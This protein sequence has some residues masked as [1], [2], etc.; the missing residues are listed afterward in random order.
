MFNNPNEDPDAAYDEKRQEAVDKGFNNII[1]MLNFEDPPAEES[2]FDQA[3][4][5]TG[6]TDKPTQE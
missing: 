6:M 5:I 2:F 1:E 3:A 4:F